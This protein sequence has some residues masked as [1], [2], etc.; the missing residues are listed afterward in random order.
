MR[1][2]R[3]PAYTA[4]YSASADLR[5]GTVDEA[6]LVLGRLTAEGRSS[7]YQVPDAILGAQAFAYMFAA[8]EYMDRMA[9]FLFSRDRS[10][11]RRF[12]FSEVTELYV[13]HRPYAYAKS[14][15]ALQTSD[16]AL[17]RLHSIAVSPYDWEAYRQSEE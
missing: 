6:S 13:S 10:G 16:S 17:M 5:G 3:V 14:S 7:T 2:C 15:A 12:I 9:I 11:P 4:T 8:V 1:C